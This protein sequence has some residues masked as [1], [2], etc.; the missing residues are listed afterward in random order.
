MYP[1]ITKLQGMGCVVVRNFAA[2]KSAGC[3]DEL[4]R[5]QAHVVVLNAL[6]VCLEASARG[7]VL[8]CPERINLDVVQLLAYEAVAGVFNWINEKEDNEGLDRTDQEPEEKGRAEGIKE[9]RV[10]LR[11]MATHMHSAELTLAG[12]NAISGA[13]C[14]I[15]IVLINSEILGAEGIKTIHDAMREHEA[16]AAIQIAGCCALMCMVMGSQQRVHV[17]RKL[18]CIPLVCRVMSKHTS[19]PGLQDLACKFLHYMMEYPEDQDTKEACAAAG[20]VS[21]L[22]QALTTHKRDA[23]VALKAVQALG[24]FSEIF[25]PQLRQ[26][27]LTEGASSAILSAMQQRTASVGLL[28]N[29]FQ[30]ICKMC[31]GHTV[32]YTEVFLNFFNKAAPVLLVVADRHKQS[33]EL[34]RVCIQLFGVYYSIS[35]GSLD[36]KLAE[37]D[38]IRVFVRCLHTFTDQEHLVHACCALG[39]S[40]TAG[41]NQDACR[42]EGAIEALLS[43]SERAKNDPK[44]LFYIR[45]LLTDMSNEHEENTRYIARVMTAKQAKIIAR[46]EAPHAPPAHEYDDTDTPIMRTRDL[47]P[48]EVDVWQ[49]ALCKKAQDM[50]LDVAA[51]KIEERDQKKKAEACTACGQTAEELGLSRMLRCSACTVSPLYCSAACQKASWSAHKAECKVNKRK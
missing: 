47:T 6:S 11:S 9:L 14:A 2:R 5:E 15:D 32:P 35:D 21:A 30:V 38:G 50:Q 39:K 26:R 33:V 12:L 3:L 1:N 24:K 28:V 17:A 13:V 23:D 37:T 42:K 20:V 27:M 43:L 22:A 31:R 4:C 34:T 8:G 41:V 40:M 45:S 46:A 44:I 7:E 16:D 29:C 51:Q 36:P 19:N 10:I 48:E 49:K 18:G 25:S